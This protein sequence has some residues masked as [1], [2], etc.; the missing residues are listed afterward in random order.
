[1][2]AGF[3]LFMDDGIMQIDSNFKTVAPAFR[4]TYAGPYTSSNTAFVGT[5]YHFTVTIPLETKYLF[6]A[7]PVERSIALIKKAGTSH[8]FVTSTPGAIE[9][10]GFKDSPAQDSGSGSGLQLFDENGVLTFD[11]ES[12]FMKVADAFTVPTS[13][14]AI[15]PWPDPTR[16]YAIGLGVYAKC[17]RGA[18]QAGLPWGV[19]MSYAIRVGPSAGGGGFTGISSR[20]WGGGGDAPPGNTP[21]AAPPTAM[22]VDVTGL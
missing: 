18:M 6:F 16:N 5:W 12:N 3:T 14:L 1:M 10:Y 8:T 20:L 9:I 7:S 21:Q 15:K 2:Q 22:I 11:S 13:G 4:L 17:W 19:L